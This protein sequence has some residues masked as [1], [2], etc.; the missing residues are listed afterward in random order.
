[1][2]RHQKIRNNRRRFAIV[3]VGD[4]KEREG[5]GR[6]VALSGD[7]L[8]ACLKAVSTLL[9]ANAAASKVTTAPR[10][11][12]MEFLLSGWGGTRSRVAQGTGRTMRTAR[13]RPG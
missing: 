10:K 9:I 3:V 12:K 4:G 7:M 11:K 6:Q 5:E 13:L 2:T 1:M 8:G